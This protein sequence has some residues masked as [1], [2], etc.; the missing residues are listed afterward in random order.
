MTNSINCLIK[1]IHNAGNITSII[2]THE[3]RT[4]YDVVDRVIMLNQRE[5]IFDDVPSKLINS[6]EEIVQQFILNKK[7]I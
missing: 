3:L 2:V 7:A 4:V 5:I 1:K 6:K